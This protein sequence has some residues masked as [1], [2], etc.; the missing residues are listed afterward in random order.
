[1]ASSNC[2]GGI[3]QD[4]RPHDGEGFSEAFGLAVSARITENTIAAFLPRRPF[5]FVHGSVYDGPIFLVK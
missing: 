1:M 2:S 4:R 3:F 5:A